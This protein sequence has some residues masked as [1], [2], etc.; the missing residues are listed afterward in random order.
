MNSRVFSDIT[1][2]T[3]FFI[4]LL[5]ILPLYA[6]D[7]GRPFAVHGELR[8]WRWLCFRVWCPQTTCVNQGWTHSF[9]GF[10]LGY[11]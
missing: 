6:Q 5:L 2:E 8:L 11:R 4:L 9:H 7:N 1:E 3:Y 10:V